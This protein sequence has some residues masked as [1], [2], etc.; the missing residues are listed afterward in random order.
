MLIDAAEGTNAS[1]YLQDTP[2]NVT[3]FVWYR[4]IGANLH[5]K[6]AT[7]DVNQNT[8]EKGPAYS[9]REEIIHNG[10]LLLTN[11]ALNDT[12]NYT[13]VAYMRGSEGE[14]RSGQL[15]VYG[16]SLLSDLRVL[17]GMNSPH[18]QD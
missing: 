13:V 8:Y 18:T 16:E 10:S 2:P 3:S 4:G 11:V 1:L 12:G 9:G 15:N 14:I 7:F 5:N 17:G 6:I